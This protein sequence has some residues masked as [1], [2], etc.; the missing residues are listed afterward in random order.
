MPVPHSINSL[1]ISDIYEVP[2]LVGK[3][4]FGDLL[5]KFDTNTPEVERPFT[6]SFALWLTGE[7]SIYDKIWIYMDIILEFS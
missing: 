7:I 1:L 5:A 2:L 3:V 4:N 6:Q